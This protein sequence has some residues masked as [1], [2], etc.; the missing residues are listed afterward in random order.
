MTFLNP[1]GLWL[2][3]GIPVLII[4]YLIRSRHEDRR[5]SSTYI[6]KLSER[7]VKKRIPIRIRRILMFLLQ[8]LMIVII[9]LMAARPATEKGEAFD[10][11]LILDG[12]ASMQIKDDDGESR[13]DRAVEKIEDLVETAGGGHS[14]SLVFATDTAV[15]LIENSSSANEVKLA[16]SK[17]ECT[18]GAADLVSAVAE[19]QDIFDAAENGKVIVYTDKQ[20]KQA[21]NITVEDMSKE[22]WNVSL[23]G[24]QGEEKTEGLVFTGVLTSYNKDATVTVGLMIDGKTVSAKR[25]ECKADTEG[26]VEFVL[27][28][29]EFYEVAQIYVDVEDGFEEDNT[30]AYCAPDTKSYKALIVSASPLY[31]ENAF[32]ALGNLDITVIDE[33][34]E[35]ELL[36]GYDLYVFDMITPEVYPDDGAV[37]VFGT[38]N[39]PGGIT[40][41]IYY[42]LAYRLKK[43]DKSVNEIISDLSFSGAVVKGYG[44]L[45]GSS[46]WE[47]LLYCNDSPVLATGKQK[48]GM[49]MAVFSFDLHNSNLPLQ[50]EYLTLMK[51]L[52]DHSLPT[53]LEKSDYSVGEKTQLTILPGT[54]KMFLR[55]PDTSLYE[56]KTTEGFFE[57]TLDK[58]GVHT[59]LMY[60]DE[61]NGEYMDFFV[62]I[63]FDEVKDL[64]GEEIN[65]AFDPDKETEKTKEEEAVSG[66]W[67]WFA[68]GML[69]L[70][71]VEWGWY[72]SEQY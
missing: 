21:G 14:F 25:V 18:F 54:E 56:I 50:K 68:L 3:L 57:I 63:P 43:S 41:G 61:E 8:L 51:N 53:M 19:A 11:I 32:K 31:I 35:D 65:I 71:L 59:A 39:L 17:A 45:I 48:N 62:H 46:D 30:Y 47:Y 9:S 58:I 15:R 13:F 36:S 26:Q 7:F 38:E 44:T 37:I 34:V 24:L 40:C 10:Y 5:V 72:Y 69:L 29:A 4:I 52:V 6:W 22:E 60:T 55:Y 23:S 1:A 64:E 67:F 49:R 42:D 12:S 16:L 70:V 66:I 33:I 20:F 28:N 27:E 2:L